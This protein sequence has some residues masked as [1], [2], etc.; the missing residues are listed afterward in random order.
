MMSMHEDQVEEIFQ[1]EGRASAS[2]MKQEPACS[3][4]GTWSP[5][6]LKQNEQVREW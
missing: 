6:Y 4:W 5:E 1:V 2:A 3:V